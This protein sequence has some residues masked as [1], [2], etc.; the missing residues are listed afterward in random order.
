MPRCMFSFTC[1]N[2][3]IELRC[4]CVCETIAPW[5]S[6]RMVVARSHRIARLGNNI[7]GQNE[8]GDD[9]APG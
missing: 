1:V 5:H 8:T 9:D 6:E 7:D 2:L 4:G 3:G